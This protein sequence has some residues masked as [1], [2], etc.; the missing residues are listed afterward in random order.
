MD[1]EADQATAGL[2]APSAAPPLRHSPTPE[3]LR[4]MRVIGRRS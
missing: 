2:D 3:T 4:Y 1:A